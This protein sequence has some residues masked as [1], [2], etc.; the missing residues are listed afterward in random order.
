MLLQCNKRFL[1]LKHVVPRALR[2]WRNRE[3]RAA[4]EAHVVDPTDAVNIAGTYRA[5]DG[6]ERKWDPAEVSPARLV[7]LIASMSS[8]S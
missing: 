1:S 5:G 6:S 2:I 7:Q 3:W 4:A 8:I